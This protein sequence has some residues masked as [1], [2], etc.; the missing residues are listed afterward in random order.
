[1]VELFEM[2]EQAETASQR[3]RLLSL[4]IVG[5]GVTGVEVAAE[6]T[7]MMRDTLLP[8][9]PGIQ[10]SDVSLTIVEGGDRL[11]ATARPRHSTYIQ[12]FLERRG[13]K[14]RLGT[15]VSRVEPRRLLIAS[16]GTID[17]F[18][19]VWTAGVCPPALV[20][21]LPLSHTKDGRVRVDERLRALD[22]AGR[23]V[24][25]VYVIGDSAAALSDGGKFQPQL[26]Q[27]SIEMGQ[28]VGHRLVNQARGRDVGPFTSHEIGYIISL[29]KHSSVLDLFGIQL[30]GKLAWLTWAA[31]YLIKMVGLRKQIEVGIDHITHSIFEHDTAQ[32]LARRNVLTD[33]EL[34]LSLAEPTGAAQR[35][36]GA[37]A[38]EMAAADSTRTGGTGGQGVERHA[39]SRNFVL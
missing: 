39:R 6:L 13:V 37:G 27:T 15:M 4:A 12:K 19:L 34:N 16:G 35:T 25:S 33:E 32:I 1:V 18:T 29:G 14:V 9:Y 8:K 7:D 3:R 38:G 21:Q 2:A 11:V 23:T 36:T 30:S 10:P 22:P 24:E 26:A 5:G 28:Y 17:A 20:Q 31:A